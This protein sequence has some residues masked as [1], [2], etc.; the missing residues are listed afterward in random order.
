M[1]DSPLQGVWDCNESDDA[2]TCLASHAWS[3]AESDT[4][5]DDFI[6]IFDQQLTLYEPLS[7]PCLDPL[8]FTPLRASRRSPLDFDSE[9]IP[10]DQPLAATDQP[11][12]PEKHADPAPKRRGRPVGTTGNA[13]DRKFMRDRQ[14]LVQ[15]VDQLRHRHRFV[16]GRIGNFRKPRG[17]LLCGNSLKEFSQ[18]VGGTGH[19]LIAASLARTE[20]ERSPAVDQ[21]LDQII[22][23]SSRPALPVTHE[24]EKLGYGQRYRRFQEDVVVCASTVYFGSRMWVSSLLSRVIGWIENGLVLPLLTVMFGMY[25]MTPMKMKAYVDAGSGRVSPDQICWDGSD[26]LPLDTPLKE[27]VPCKVYRSDYT[28][29]ILLKQVEE[30]E[31]FLVCI[32]PVCPLHNADH[33]TGECN[34]SISHESSFVPLFEQLRVVAKKFGAMN[35]DLRTL[36]RDGANSRAEREMDVELQG[37]VDRGKLP[38]M[39]HM[40]STTQAGVLGTIAPIVS[41]AI[42]LRLAMA[43]PGAFGK[44]REVVVYVLLLSVNVIQ[45]EPPP[46]DSECSRFTAGLL[47]TF[48][49]NNVVDR[50]RK[51]DLTRDLT[52]NWD[53]DEI[54][55]HT[56]EDNPDLEKWAKRVA[57]NLLPKLPPL[58]NRGR[59]IRSVTTW[60]ETGLLRN[61]HRLLSRSNW[62]WLEYLRGAPL[63]SI[64]LERPPHCHNS[65]AWDNDS[66]S[67]EE[68]ANEP[69]RPK[70]ADEWVKFNAKQ[71]KGAATFVD[72]NVGSTLCIVTRNMQ[73]NVRLMNSFLSLS[74]EAWQTKQF[75]KAIR[76]NCPPL[77]A[78]VGLVCTKHEAYSSRYQLSVINSQLASATFPGGLKTPNS[79]PI[80][81]ARVQCL[82]MIMNVSICNQNI[83]CESMY[84]IKYD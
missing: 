43:P 40:V 44:F 64:P 73:N 62:I 54:Q 42:S 68:N 65:N 18:P 23:P 25:D 26:A 14:P 10:S 69:S 8:S 24:A 78:M 9:T 74:G 32:P 60:R 4:D 1:S 37:L 5:N 63:H 50:E 6:N 70:T 67:D 19:R 79:F 38:C 80:F 81:S 47:D 12:T 3:C 83:C 76:N 56:L 48:L 41:G 30:D 35:V 66:D 15:P 82:N 52:S 61:C 36:D 75:A 21:L 16:Q 55:W 53:E 27:L 22:G 13:R 57:S 71:R 51:Y 59:W 20:V 17:D 33:S 84:A 2:S 29:G 46:T 72:T 45:A 7:Q 34:K 39:V 11:E 49:E 58:L 31:S 28:L 77:L